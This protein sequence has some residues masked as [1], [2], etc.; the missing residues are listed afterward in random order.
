[1]KLK[2]PKTL[3]MVA[4]VAA[5]GAAQFIGRTS[6]T[7]AQQGPAKPAA[8]PAK[9]N[10]LDKG[11]FRVGF[12]P[13]T[14]AKTPKK[15]MPADDKA[16]L[17]E[18]AT[19]LNSVIALPK[20]IYLNIDTCGE[21]NAFYSSET[22]EITFC[23]ELIDQYDEEFKTITKNQAKVD[24]MVQDTLQQTLFH[25]MGHCLI[26]VWDLPATGREEDAVDQLATILMLD[27]TKE[28]QDSA[29]NAAKEF[30]I[31]SKSE[32]NEDMKFWDEHS[33]SKTRFYDMICL[34]Y[35]SNADKNSN[36]IG[37][38]KL[39]AERAEGCEHEFDR[40]E[41]SWLKLLDPYLIK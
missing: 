7:T 36:L 5:L 24:E 37:P 41:R 28:G 31:A 35:G 25:E 34:V 18:V 22:N 32:G 19:A 27:G 8:G 3:L 26:D 1:M 20:D 40:A 17:Q 21:P 30:E 29:L 12:S 9:K 38:D 6:H 39:P 14:K 13:Q 10:P 23:N 33:F 2:F 11:D 16:T 15:E 4:V